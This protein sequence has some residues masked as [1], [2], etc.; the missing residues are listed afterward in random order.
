MTRP[1][2]PLVFSREVQFGLGERV[3]YRL[4][5]SIVGMVVGYKFTLSG[6][7]PVYVV[8]WADNRAYMEHTVGELD[9][10]PEEQKAGF[11]D[12]G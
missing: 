6:G 12:V 7:N 5:P 3:I 10:A 1:I 9:E 11:K 2:K 8:S 4:A